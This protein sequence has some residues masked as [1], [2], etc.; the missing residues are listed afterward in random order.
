MG[1]LADPRRDIEAARRGGDLDQQMDGE[2]D[3]SCASLEQALFWRQ[4]YGEILAME[5]KVMERIEDLMALQSDK[6]RREVEL[7]NVP[8]VAS[9]LERFRK[10]MGYWDHRVRQLQLPA[11]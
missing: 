7:T 1:S 11:P 5:E 4:I 10:R 9:Q 6:V 2:A 8:V 3:L